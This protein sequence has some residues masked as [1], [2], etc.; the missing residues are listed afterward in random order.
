[1]KFVFVDPPSPPN[2]VAFR[3]AHGGLGEFCHSSRLKVPT[4]DLFHCASIVL[5]HGAQAALVDSVLLD[6][7]IE[8]CATAVLDARP[9]FIAIRTASGS[10]PHD[11]KVAERLRQNFS[12][13]IVFCGPHAA[14]EADALLASSAVDAV[15][16]GEA[17]ALFLALAQKN[18]ALDVPGVLRKGMARGAARLMPD[19]DVLPVP[20]WD[21]VDY[22]KYTFVTAQTS[23]GCPLGCSYCPY[24]VTQ[25]KAW[26]TR[27]VAAV[28]NEFTT[29]GTKY[30][31]PFV[32][33]R[34]PLFTLERKRTLELCSALAQAGT[35]IM[36]GCETRIDTLDEELIAAMAAAGCIRVVYG[37]ESTR[38]DVLRGVGRR[39]ATL[40][41]TRKTTALLKR[42]GMLTYAFY[43]IGLPGET[44]DSTR[45]MIDFAIDLD[46]NAAS[47]SAATPFKGTGLERLGRDTGVITT[48]DPLHLT[49]CIPSMR[50]AAMSPEE[51]GAFYRE[52]KKRWSER[53]QVAA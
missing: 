48:K 29:L 10:C 5:K 34:D 41:Q 1:M 37:V 11:L 38:P 25:G 14:V 31:L 13:P 12:G 49:S 28:V 40:E 35:P 4:L 24:P 52:A 16:E 19:L 27:S 22:R 42:Y 47:F 8:E 32:M 50:N 30:K 15:I 36:W 2:S 21:L 44:P 3:H 43:M 39:G 51:I 23:W 53:K 33:L 9:D 17:P 46:T 18:G 7:T 26:R 45:E 6:H 20:R